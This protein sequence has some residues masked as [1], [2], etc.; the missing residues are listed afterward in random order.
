MIPDYWA[1]LE[2][3]GADLE[4]LLRSPERFLELWTTVRERR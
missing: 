3:S 4:P 2:A 1:R